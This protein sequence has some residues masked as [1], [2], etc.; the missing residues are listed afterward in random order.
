MN[1][2][3]TRR[4]WGRLL[5]P[6]VWAGTLGL[7]LIAVLG[8]RRYVGR[9]AERLPEFAC[10]TVARSD[11]PIVITERGTV[12]AQQVTEIKC[13]VESTAHNSRA[14]QGTQIVYIIPNGSRVKKGDLLVELDSSAIR[15]HMYEHVLAHYQAVSFRIRQTALYEN[16]K[17]QNETNLASAKLRV[18]LAEKRLQMYL[19]EEA[20][21]YK[22]ARDEALRD[23]LEK[24][25]ALT[26]AQNEAHGNEQLFQ[27]GYCSRG[28]LD[29]ARYRKIQAQDALDSAVSKQKQLETYEHRMQRLRLEGAVASAHRYLQ[30]VVNDSAALLLQ[31]EA[32][33]RQAERS[34]ERQAQSVERLRVQVEKCKIYA[35]HDGMVVYQQDG[36]YGS[37]IAEGILVYRYQTL[38]TLPDPSRMQ[39]KTEIHEAV[40]DQ[41][42]PN[43]AAKIRVD[44]CPGKLFT[45]TVREVSFLPTTQSYGWLSTGVKTYQTIVHIE[46]DVS[47]LK[48]GMTA[49]VEIQ[50]DPIKDALT[51]PVQAVVQRDR[52]NWCYISTRAGVE[53]RAVQLG[54]SN[55]EFVHVREG[56]TAGDRVVLDPAPLVELENAGRKEISPVLGMPDMPPAL[57]GPGQ[58]SPGPR[59]E[60]V[61]LRAK[62]AQ[63]VG[64]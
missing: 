56:L 27:L 36:R 9:S 34:E 54:K 25:V 43:M 47:N 59:P 8:M 31:A 62:D 35:P 26:M 15:E 50:V 60:P 3:Q 39:V 4:F 49:V 45:G 32:A 46:G 37:S 20:G 21:T 13:E 44:A 53:K 51:V 48:P 29:K 64:G 33:K 57:A 14:V 10:Y 63:A 16:Q 19:D 6:A 55:G 52:D 11:L 2:G 1:V 18:E 30:Q 61:Q 22:L 12:G 41:V 23:I 38:L 28:Q 42:R 7:I 5:K 58:P 17:L 24:R 40:L